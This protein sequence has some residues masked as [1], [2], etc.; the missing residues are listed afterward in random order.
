MPAYCSIMEAWGENFENNEQ[1]FENLTTNKGFYNSNEN[2]SNTKFKIPNETEPRGDAR[3]IPPPN[4]PIVSYSDSETEI[5]MESER[6]P[7][8]KYYKKEIK[9]YNLKGTQKLYDIC[10]T[11]PKTKLALKSFY[12]KNNIDYD[13]DTED[14]YTTEDTSITENFNV[15]K[16]IKKSSLKLHD[17]DVNDMIIF[18][19]GGIFLI[20]IMDNMLKSKKY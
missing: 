18:I 7:K 10:K 15:K 11:I 17:D 2:G 4:Y 12:E 14:G 6:I 20:F 9:R 19:M 1:K 3:G 8:S 16:R 13:T 5:E